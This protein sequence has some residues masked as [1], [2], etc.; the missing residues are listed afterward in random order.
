M[1]E[2]KP[3]NAIEWTRVYGRRGWTWNPVAGC[4]HGCRW[5]MPDGAVAEC[6]AENVAE[7]VAQKAYPHGFDHHYWHP[8]ILEQPL[9]LKEPGGIFVGSMAD[10]FGA[11]VP[12]DQI[13]QVLDVCRRAHWH[14]FILLTKNIPRA[15]KFGFPSNVWVGVSSPPDQMHGKPLNQKQQ[16][17]MLRRSL[18]VLRQL[19]LRGVMTWLSAEPLSW[20]ISPYLMDGAI[21]WCVIGAASDGRRQFPPSAEAFQNTLAKLDGFGVATFFKGNLKSLPEAAADWREAFPVRESVPLL[22]APKKPNDF[23]VTEVRFG[24]R[25]VWGCEKA[26]TEAIATYPPYKGSGR[27]VIVGTLQKWQ[28]MYI[29]VIVCEARNRKKRVETPKVIRL[30]APAPEPAEPL[31]IYGILDEL[32]DFSRDDENFGEYDLWLTIKDYPALLTVPALLGILTTSENED[33][34]RLAISLLGLLGDESIV[35]KLLPFWADDRIGGDDLVYDMADWAIR[36]LAPDVHAGLFFW[37]AVHRAIKKGWLG[38]QKTKADN[39]QKLKQAQRIIAEAQ[40]RGEEWLFWAVDTYP[41]KEVYATLLKH[42]YVW[43][44]GKWLSEAA[45]T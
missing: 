22:P 14:T 1:N 21:D 35:P 41:S 6:Y 16:I 5:T 39:G 12:E 19:R 2:Q 13:S 28:S 11:W 32:V 17:A 40:Q 7:G 10:L 31:S 36:R 42:G 43:H 20:D 18:G 9:K 27:N 8:E 29:R 45:A 26:Y 44:Q 30:P 38:I 3:P 15:L 4:H 25:L 24:S 34:I 23:R 33:Y 37:K